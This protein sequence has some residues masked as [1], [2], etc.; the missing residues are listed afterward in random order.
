MSREDL[1]TLLGSLVPFAQQQLAEHGTFAPFAG[2][3]TP[4]GQ[5]RGYGTR[6][7]AEGMQPSEVMDMLMANLR[8]AAKNGECRAGGI[9]CDVSVAREAGGEKVSAIAVSLEDAEGTAMEC[10]MPYSKT[11]AGEYEYEEVFGGLVP[12]NI[13]EKPV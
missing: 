10:F 4:D 3:M 2:T 1:A 7:E 9:C 8:E 6:P 11:A 5:V 13:F 12:P